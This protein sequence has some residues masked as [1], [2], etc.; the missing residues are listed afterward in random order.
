MREAATIE[1]HEGS[2][3]FRLQATSEALCS[4]NSSNILRL[5]TSSASSQ[6]ARYV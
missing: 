6:E 3:D 2:V 5:R 1:M 4:K